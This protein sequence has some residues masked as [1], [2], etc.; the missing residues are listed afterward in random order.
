MIRALIDYLTITF[1]LGA[2]DVGAFLSELSRVCGYQLRAVDE[3]R[4]H[5]FQEG[6]IVQAF[7]GMQLVEFG[8]LCWGGEHQRGRMMWTQSG[9]C[10]GAVVAWAP[11]RDFLESLPASKITRCDVCVD[12]F[13][14]EHTVDDGISWVREGLFNC[15]GRNPKTKYIGGIDDQSDGQTLY[16]GKSKNGKMLRVYEKGRQLG[17][18][19]SPWVRWEV[20]FG[21]RD[22]LLPFDILTDPTR[23]FLGAYPALEALAA[24]QSA[25]RIETIQR[26]TEFQLSAI[27]RALQSS[28]GRWVG[29]CV[30]AGAD[31]LEFVDA[32]RMVGLPRRV[33]SSAVVRD[34]LA[35]AALSAINVQRGTICNW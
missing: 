25:S 9:A 35:G 11:Y 13:D 5:G 16:V 21:S 6:R 14:G 12:F 31:P 17:D 15:A 33:Q 29:V 2:D 26:S 30:D 34:Q 8:R 28:Y 4:L 27:L 24:T 10:C 23:F 7:V 32:V 22:R 18:P 19:D 20:Q 3:C 1:E